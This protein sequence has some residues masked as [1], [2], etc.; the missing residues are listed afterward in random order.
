MLP[1]RSSIQTAAFVTDDDLSTGETAASLVRF[2]SACPSMLARQ[3]SSPGRACG[4][5][6]AH[7]MGMI[8]WRAGTTESNPRAPQANAASPVAATHQLHTIVL[9]RWVLIIATSYLVLF[10]RPLSEVTPSVAL[11]VAAY[12]ASNVALTEL[13]PRL[14]AAGVLDWLVILVDTVAL[15]VALALTQSS[16]SDFYVLY[17]AV[18]FLSALSERI[19]LVVGAA[20]LVTLTHLYTMSHFLDVNVLLQRGYM[21]RVPFLFVV[22]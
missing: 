4:T 14:R 6:R 20:L 3:L 12:L 13:A 7:S 11:F 22:A 21:L 1:C 2:Y 5:P 16:S 9:L 10:S 8:S 18:L 19:G 15:S 17:F